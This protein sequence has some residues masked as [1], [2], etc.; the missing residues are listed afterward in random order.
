MI[1]RCGA[2]MLALEVKSATAAPVARCEESWIASASLLVICSNLLVS[3]VMLLI[4]LRSAVPSGDISLAFNA[5]FDDGVVA[6]AVVNV[7]A[8]F[9]YEVVAEAI[10][11]IIADFDD[12]V[13]YSQ[14]ESPEDSD[15][16]KVALEVADLH[17][18]PVI[19]FMKTIC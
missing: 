9:N 14:G 18:A 1:G 8:N 5:D 11:D 4:D 2:V 3:S 12:E 7:I 19:C 16:A 6:E 15:S 13:E 17:L 10:V